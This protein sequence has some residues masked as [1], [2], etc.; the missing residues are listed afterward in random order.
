MAAP[1]TKSG[2]S[3]KTSPRQKRGLTGS[4]VGVDVSDKWHISICRLSLG[5]TAALRLRAMWDYWLPN[6]HSFC[7]WLHS[8]SCDSYYTWA[9]VVAVHCESLIDAEIIVIAFLVFW[10][11]EFWD[12]YW[13]PCLQ[14]MYP[15]SKPASSVR[16]GKAF[17]TIV[18]DVQKKR[19]PVNV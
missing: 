2:Q 4:A 16:F 7:I 19:S 8:D 10:L 1:R 11:L 9:L 18:N 12:Q 17:Q 15:N 6:D 13:G 5:K 14:T 3:G